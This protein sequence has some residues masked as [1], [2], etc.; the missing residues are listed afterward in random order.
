MN[1]VHGRGAGVA[2]FAIGA[3]TEVAKQSGMKCAQNVTAGG[4]ANK[5]GHN[6]VKAALPAA[7]VVVAAAPA[8]AVVAGVAAV[9]YGVYRLG[10]WL[11]E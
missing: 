11:S 6:L 7:A 10:K 9:S 3:V 4:M 2:N 8:V 5:A 1:D